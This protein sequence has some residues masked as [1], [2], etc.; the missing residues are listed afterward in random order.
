MIG[1]VIGKEIGS[2]ADEVNSVMDDEEVMLRGV[3]EVGRE[4]DVRKVDFVL[5]F[6]PQTD[7]AEKQF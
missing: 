2:I 5:Y 1:E 4:S 6:H 7:C 3:G